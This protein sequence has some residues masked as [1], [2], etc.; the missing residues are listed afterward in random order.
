MGLMEY[1]M[2]EEEPFWMRRAKGLTDSSL[3][4]S[5][6]LEDKMGNP[7]TIFSMTGE[8]EDGSGFMF[9]TIR[10]REPQN[11]EY[12][13]ANPYL[14]RM[15]PRQAMMETLK[16]RDFISFPSEKK[17]T[18]FARNFSPTIKRKKKKR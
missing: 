17:A 18:E 2:R 7:Q 4:N 11:N 6:Y 13:E 8:L 3:A 5:M 14:E 9:P 10:Y 1:L 15:I 12:K 16:K